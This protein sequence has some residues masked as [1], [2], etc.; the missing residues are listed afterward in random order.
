MHW[1]AAD[2]ESG[3]DTA[4][5]PKELV[6]D[7]EDLFGEFA[8]WGQDECGALGGAQEGFDQGN[9]EGGGFPGSGLG[10]AEDVVALYRQGDG[11]N[12]DRGWACVIHVRE[13]FV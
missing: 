8:C 12:L 13:G 7:I 4:F 1:F 3:V 6:D 10:G 2:D 9:G 5:A 11:L